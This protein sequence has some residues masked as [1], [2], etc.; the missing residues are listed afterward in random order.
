[1][2]FQRIPT[3]SPLDEL[4][5]ILKKDDVVILMTS[6]DLGGLIESVPK[7]AEEMFPKSNN[8]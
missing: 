4:R 5:K 3:S 8:G 6:G 1:M 2:D 7:L